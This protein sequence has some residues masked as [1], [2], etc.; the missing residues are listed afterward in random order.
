MLRWSSRAWI[1][2]KDDGV[3]GRQIELPGFS[4]ASHSM[5]W[6]VFCAPTC[7][8]KISETVTFTVI[9]KFLD[10]ESLIPTSGIFFGKLVRGFPI[11]PTSWL[12]Q[13]ILSSLIRF[14]SRLHIS[15]RGQ[16]K[17]HYHHFIYTTIQLP[18]QSIV[19]VGRSRASQSSRT[20]ERNTLP[21]TQTR[22][23]GGGK[24]PD[25]NLAVT[26]FRTMQW[27]F[28]VWHLSYQTFFYNLL[29][30][31]AFPTYERSHSG[32]IPRP[33]TLFE[34]ESSRHG[35]WPGSPMVYLRFSR[36]FSLRRNC[37]QIYAAI[38]PRHTMMKQIHRRK[39]YLK[40][41]VKLLWNLW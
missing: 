7:S 13:P 16:K 3:A 1:S 20:E 36:W 33:R 12:R 32:L 14:L 17:N 38:V 35:I 37:G 41:R 28:V 22:Q 9:C 6:V 2:I 19:F 25:R 11:P 34:S 31:W 4:A 8:S 23:W 27:Y 21:W 5:E 15:R 24:M 29:N 26:L 39:L 40:C 30:L 18:L 10:R